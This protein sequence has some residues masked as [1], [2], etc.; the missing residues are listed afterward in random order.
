MNVLHSL[1]LILLGP[2][3]LL[4]P[5]RSCGLPQLIFM[6]TWQLPSCP[7][8]ALHH[9]PMALFVCLGDLPG[10]GLGQV[11]MAIS[12][13]F[14]IEPLRD[15]ALGPEIAQACSQPTAG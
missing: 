4:T 14:Q 12:H 7:A 11:A 15:V 6:E 9:I 13:S 3:S 8:P 1:G 10:L 5:S 2:D